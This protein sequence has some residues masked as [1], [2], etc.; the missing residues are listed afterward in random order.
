MMNLQE[1]FEVVEKRCMAMSSPIQSI[2]TESVKTLV[3]AS[4]ISRQK[5]PESPSV[6]ESNMR[7]AFAE[8]ANTSKDL[9]RGLIPSS[10]YMYTR[11][12]TEQVSSL[13]SFVNTKCAC[14]PSF[15]SIVICH[16][17]MPQ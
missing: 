6:S 15:Y 7:W 5:L 1:A 12:H 17:Q 11:T 16:S 4:C 9:P 14:L 8:T 3:E 10:M 13:S 2:E